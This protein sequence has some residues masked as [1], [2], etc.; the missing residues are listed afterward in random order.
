MLWKGNALIMFAHFSTINSVF[1]MR[2]RRVFGDPMENR[3][4]MTTR[5]GCSE[6]PQWNE[7]YYPPQGG[8]LR[9]PPTRGPAVAEFK[10][11]LHLNFNDAA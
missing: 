10:T 2:Q 11:V 1:P 8:T 6:L 4:A 5:D 9:T 3:T 7:E